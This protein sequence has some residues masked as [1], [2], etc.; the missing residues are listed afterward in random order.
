MLCVSSKE[1][2]TSPHRP[3]TLWRAVRR[4]WLVSRASSHTDTPPQC[5]VREPVRDTNQKPQT[6]RHKSYLCL[7]YMFF[8]LRTSAVSF[9]HSKTAHVTALS[10]KI[11]CAY[12]FR[13]ADRLSNPKTKHEH[14]KQVLGYIQQWLQSYR[15]VLTEFVCSWSLQNWGQVHWRLFKCEEKDFQE[16]MKS[17]QDSSKYLTITTVNEHWTYFKQLTCCN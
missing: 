7:R 13:F 1:N 5:W 17:L 16:W 6:E 15:Q 8:T 11:E 3:E 2:V 12:F 10:P 9:T 14:L 4:F